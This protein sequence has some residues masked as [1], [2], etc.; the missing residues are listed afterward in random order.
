MWGV[1]YYCGGEGF[2][3]DMDKAVEWFTKSAEQGFEPG[4]T[5]LDMIRNEEKRQGND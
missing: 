5:F 1:G 3:K 4:R 2:E